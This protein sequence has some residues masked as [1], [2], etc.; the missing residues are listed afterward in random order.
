MTERRKFSR[1]IYQTPANI[2]QDGVKW[3]SNI[4]DLSLKG[5]LLTTPLDWI[6]GNTE[7]YEITFLLNESDILIDMDLKLIQEN[8]DHLRFEIDHIDI[9]SASHLKRLIELNVGNDALLHRE[10]EQLTDLKDVI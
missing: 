3:Q 10:L 5:A 2:E 1:V 9:N 6:H 8:K 7:D 4:L